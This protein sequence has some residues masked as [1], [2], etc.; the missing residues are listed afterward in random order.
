MTHSPLRIGI[1]GIDSSHAPT[2]TQLL[3]DNE[4]PFHVTGGK[5][6]VAYPGGSPDFEMSY[7]RIEGFTT[8]LRDRGVTIVDSPEEVAANCD[9]IL[10]TSVD[11]RIHLEQFRRVLS[12]RK[13]IFIDKPMTVSSAEA[14]EIIALAQQNNIPLMSCSSLRYA[15][16]LTIA[17]H[18][19]DNSPIIGMDCYGPMALQATQPGLF[20]YGVH[21]VEMLF[22]V[23][24][25]N[26]LHVTAA[27][28][29]DHDVI[30]GVWDNGVIGTI[31][32]NRKGNG[33][34]G[35]LIHQESR[36]QFVDVNK[37]PKPYYAS[38]LEKIMS[39]F[40]TGSPE[41][42]AEETVQIIRF[43]EA[44]NE[45]RQTGLTVNL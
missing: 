16:E 1:I 30:T 23:L 2:F 21:T 9:G 42:D 32:G 40:V 39:M 15:E 19:A 35:A 11:G 27:T 10:M 4:H 12:Y 26:C 44:A 13:P 6:T 18:A 34:F 36:T 8:Q 14:R 45:S 5:V 24:G 43:M 25:K 29:E 41:I 20:W 22:R 31:R 28:T 33:Q 3:N 17:L 37:H 38:L 7:S